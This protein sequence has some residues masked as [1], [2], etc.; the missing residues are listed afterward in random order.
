MLAVAGNIC[1]GALTGVPAILMGRSV[2]RAIESAPQHWS[3]RGTAKFAI[4]LGWISV[5]ETTF[6]LTLTFAHGYLSAVSAI[7]F[8]LAGL[9]LVAVTYLGKVPVLRRAQIALG[10]PFTGV[11]LGGTLGLVSAFGRDAATTARCEQARA[12]Y[13]ASLKNEDFAAARANV[14]TI[15]HDCKTHDDVV[16]MSREI[17]TKAAVVT[18]RKE[19]EEKDRQ[20]KAA[21]D[22][23]K[24][25]VET[26]PTKTKEISAS[27]K[28]AQTNRG[29][30]SGRI[31]KRTW[32]PLR[33]HSTISRGRASSSRRTTSA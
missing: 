32:T 17:D 21:A 28:S 4:V 33:A 8:G 22:K 24:K 9:A 30:Q 19:Q 5:C 23:E 25:A 2:L 27:L 18:K 29:Q 13:P 10:V 1:L 26:F 14:G 16:A 31:R 3:G 20:A 7:L 15:L 12:A 11:L 6:V